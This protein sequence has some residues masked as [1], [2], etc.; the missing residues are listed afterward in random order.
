MADT[1]GN[2]VLFQ[3]SALGFEPSFGVKFIR[4]FSE[5]LFAA[6]YHPRVYAEN[7]LWALVSTPDMLELLIIKLTPSVKKRPPTVRPP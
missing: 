2:P 4:I 7:N 1:H 5:N 3:I 6:M